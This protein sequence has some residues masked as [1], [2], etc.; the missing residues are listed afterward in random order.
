VLPNFG[1][2]ISQIKPTVSGDQLILEQSSIAALTTLLS[3][4]LEAARLQAARSRS[5][6]NLKHIALAMFNYHDANKGFP[7]RV[8]TSP[9]GKPLLSWRVQLLPFLDAEG[10]YKEF[11]LDE[12]WDSEH[13]RQLIARMPAVF[14]NPSRDTGEGRTSYLA[15]IL[16][17]G[18]FHGS[19]TLD[20]REI[21]DGTSN[22]IMFVEADAD[23]DTIWT[24]PDDL[25]I[26]LGDS[27]KGLVN[28]GWHGFLAA[29]ADGSVR[30]F[31]ETADKKTVA[32]HFTATGKEPIPR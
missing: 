20:F 27:L 29:F 5:T 11:H 22:T 18:I 19:K 6:S 28:P 24:K 10:L 14:R 15:P 21:V 17:Q 32:A 25:E 31:S 13:N 23:H 7:P 8:L 2:V 30:F 4:P 9:E 3:P 12:P 1:S 16:E 26:D